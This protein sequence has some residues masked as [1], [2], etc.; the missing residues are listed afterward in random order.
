MEGHAKEVGKR[1]QEADVGLVEGAGLVGVDLEHTPYTA[2]EHDGNVDGRDDAVIAQGL[3]VAEVRIVRQILD[4]TG[5]AV[6]NLACAYLDHDPG[7]NDPK[8][9]RALCQRCHILHDRTEHLR[10]RWFTYRHHSQAA[11]GTAQL[12]HLTRRPASH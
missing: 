11:G 10:Q 2:I 5:E 1:G 6:C 9:L 8:N 12:A 7:N 3:R 4:T